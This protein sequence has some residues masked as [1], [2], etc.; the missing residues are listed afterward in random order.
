MIGI[1]EKLSLTFKNILIFLGTTLSVVL[2]K[3][4]TQG[5]IERLGFCVLIVVFIAISAVI[6]IV[7]H[8][9]NVTFIAQLMGI[10]WGALAGAFLAP[11]LYGLYWKRTTKAAVWVNIIFSTVF[12][13]L[14]MFVKSIFPTILQSPI[15]A[16]AFCMLAGLIIVPVVSLLTKKPDTEK[17]DEVFSCYDKQVTVSA[18]NSIGE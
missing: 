17:V 7:Q 1:Q 2:H 13:L 12:M 9:S 16:D 6:A 4:T 15:N 8:A 10:S 11:F 18:K 3:I 5:A 14:N